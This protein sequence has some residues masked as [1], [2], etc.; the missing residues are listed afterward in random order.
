M[1]IKE[2][3]LER[4]E[5]CL[6]L[7]L[8]EGY[9]W[10]DKANGGDME[11]TVDGF[12][13]E[14]KRIIDNAK[15]LAYFYMPYITD[16]LSELEYVLGLP[17]E[18]LTETERR[19]RADSRMQLLFTD[20]GRLQLYETIMQT[21][22]F[23]DVVVRTLGAYGVAESPYDFFTN[24]GSAFFGQE[25]TE[26]G[27]LDSI[28]NNT[29]VGGGAYLVTNGGSIN[30][31]EDPDNALVRLEQNPEY[32]PYYLVVEGP[33]GAQLQVPRRRFETFFD[34]IYIWKPADMH[35]I[36]NVEFTD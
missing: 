36:L 32:W 14:Y 1:T 6:K 18:D 28:Y 5:R 30:Y 8:P 20:K 4:V 31:F 22:G 19:E 3:A 27:N 15:R 10:W 12:A 29:E 25:G 35:V 26:F 9:L 11:S 23:G 24:I 34:L 33:E 16:W 21:A 2:I 7:L 13:G 17:A